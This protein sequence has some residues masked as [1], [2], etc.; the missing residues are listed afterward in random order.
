M[1]AQ[2]QLRDEEGEEADPLADL[3][4]FLEKQL[5]ILGGFGATKQGHASKAQQWRS[6]WDA[7]KQYGDGS[8]PAKEE[9][10]HSRGCN[11]YCGD[12]HALIMATA[13]GS[14]QWSQLQFGAEAHELMQRTGHSITSLQQGGRLLLFGGHNLQ[15]ESVVTEMNDAWLLELLPARGAPRLR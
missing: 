14:P 6:I 9:I 10:E 1:H 4:S 11:H 5:V 15:R 7:F 2:T 8:D 3:E 13:T 12:C